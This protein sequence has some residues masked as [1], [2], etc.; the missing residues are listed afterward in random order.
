MKLT[1]KSICFRLTLISCGILWLVGYL[2]YWVPI[3]ITFHQNEQGEYCGIR[4]EGGFFS[5]YY[6]T[7]LSRVSPQEFFW[8]SGDWVVLRAGLCR[9]AKLFV[10]RTVTNR[11]GSPISITSTGLLQTPPKVDFFEGI[12]YLRNE[13]LPFLFVLAI[14][15]IYRKSIIRWHRIRRNACPTCGYDRRGNPTE[16]CPECGITFDPEVG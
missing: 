9:S 4:W 6:A 13:F 3:G 16:R 12:I 11:A 10:T 15:A 14:F 8:D 5:G 1:V 7:V 2:S